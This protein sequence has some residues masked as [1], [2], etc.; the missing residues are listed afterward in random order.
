MARK[1]SSIARSAIWISTALAATLAAAGASA[2]SDVQ[3]VARVEAGRQSV[4]GQAGSRRF[5]S[6][7]RGTDVVPPAETE[8][9]KTYQNPFAGP[10]SSPRYVVPRFQPGSL[11]RWHRSVEP[12]VQN[13]DPRPVHAVMQ[14]REPAREQLD[15]SGPL[16]IQEKR[17]ALFSVP[18][19]EPRVGRRK[20]ATRSRAVRCSRPRPTDLAGADG[21]ES[22]GCSGRGGQIVRRR[23]GRR[24]SSDRSIR[25][26]DTPE[27]VVSDDAPLAAKPAP[28][29]VRPSPPLPAIA[30]LPA[31]P[32]PV[33]SA[34]IQSEPVKLEPVAVPAPPDA[35]QCY[36]QAEQVA[37]NAASTNEF[38]AVVRLCQEGLAA[39]PD[40]EF[41]VCA[42]QPGG[43]GL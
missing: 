43:V 14:D 19:S 36:S 15:L 37:S 30:A 4:R 7:G 2:Q 29:Q 32:E 1:L 25:E 5:A 17:T 3:V 23:A 39:E 21:N 10:R 40:P 38:A 34:R 6:R 41:D 26:A 8:G 35:E 31:K 42:P 27:V 16:A 18:E 33:E 11:S 24:P 28:K 13:S 22:G 9:P 20:A 12:P